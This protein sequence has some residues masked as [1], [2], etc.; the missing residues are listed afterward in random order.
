VYFIAE[1]FS[2]YIYVPIANPET[3]VAQALEHFEH[4][5]D[6]DLK[7]RLSAYS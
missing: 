7:C 5:D 2:S 1:L 4:F 3:L 6:P